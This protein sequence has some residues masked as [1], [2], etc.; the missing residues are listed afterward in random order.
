MACDLRA[1]GPGARFA[2]TPAKY[3]IAYPQE[4]VARLVALVGPGQASRLLL[5]SGAIDAAEAV[6]IGLAELGPDEPLGPLSEAILANSPSSI[7]LL[8]QAIRLAASG[9]RRHPG[10]DAA[11]DGLFGSPDFAERLARARRS[12]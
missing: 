1:A 6:R 4:D 9:I 10:Q 12:R 8:K 2:I 5:G 3:G 7:A 11:F